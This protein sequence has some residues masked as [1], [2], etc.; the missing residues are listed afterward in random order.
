MWVQQPLPAVCR[1]STCGGLGSSSV[2]QDPP[3]GRVADR[4]GDKEGLEVGGV[5]LLLPLSALLPS[6]PLPVSGMSHSIFSPLTGSKLLLSFLLPIS[7]R[8]P[9][10][11][12]VMLEKR[13]GR[14]ITRTLSTTR[15]RPRLS[16]SGSQGP[17]SVFPEVDHNSCSQFREPSAF[18]WLLG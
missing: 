16:H 3:R 14:A 17:G 7:P 12:G 1:R 13:R 10:K 18:F 4:R 11:V 2:F 15:P 5:L 8:P 6:L 9:I